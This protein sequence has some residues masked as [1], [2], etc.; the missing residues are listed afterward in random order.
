MRPFHR[1]LVDNGG[2]SGTE[3]DVDEPYVAD[4]DL[5]S[6][7][8][9]EELAALLDE[10][11]TRS[12]RPPLRTLAA[13]T[14]HSQTPLS[15]TTVGE[16]L[17]GTRPPRKAVMVEFLRACGLRDETIEPWQRA[18]ERAASSARRATRA[19]PAPDYAGSPQAGA[20][21]PPA[22]TGSGADQN[23]LDDLRREVD[24]L[25][26]ENQALRI[27]V[28][29][30]PTTDGAEPQ[31]AD[32]ELSM[33]HFADGAPIT[34]VSYRLPD[35]KRPSYAK[36]QDP[37]YTRYAELADLDALVDIY[38]IVNAYN[39][40]AEIDIRPAQ[41]LLPAQVASHLILV[42]GLTWEAVTPWFSRIFAIPIDP[43]DPFEQGAI[44]VHDSDGTE[45]RFRHTSADGEVVEDVG[46]FA[47][48]QNPSAP[49]RTLTICGGITTRGVHGAARCF[50]DRELRERNEEYLRTRFPAGATYCVVMRIPIVNTDPL[51]PDLSRD[52]NVLFEWATDAARP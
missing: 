50:I 44:V 40:D 45:Q 24:A 51:A 34:L 27:R 43:G 46:F 10:V 25:R 52:G 6:V 2:Q 47:R 19:K 39:P 18:W 38:G 5:S 30:A 48:G 41:D 28:A 35:D 21:P 23:H 17:K 1:T 13:R 12:D 11:Y 3:A 42:G 49:R 22:D 7:D 33:W 8:T 16:M 36:P 15:K 31:A 4:L 9:H 14:R 32:A 20:A 26:A 29:D 37:N